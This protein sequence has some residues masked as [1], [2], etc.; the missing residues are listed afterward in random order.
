MQWR[1]LRERVPGWVLL[2]ILAFGGTL[3][4]SLFAV[5][6]RSPVEPA[7]LVIL[8][9]MA[10]RAAGMLPEWGR[11]GVKSFEKL[12]VVGIVLIGAGF[13]LRIV[14]RE[15][16]GILLLI[17]VTMMVGGGATWFCARRA[18]LSSRLGILLAVGTTICG[19]T[20]IA[21]CAPLLRAEE[22]ETS[23]A[24]GTV[25]IWGVL[26]LFTYPLLGS[27][28]GVED[29]LFGYF[30]GTAVHSTPQVVAAG[31]MYSDAAGEV[32][33]GVKLIRNCF[34]APLVLFLA[35]RTSSHAT[36]REAARG[37]PWFLFGYF[38]FAGCRTAELF[39]EPFFRESVALG[40]FFILCGMA[41]IGLNTDL[42]LVRRV[43][44]T[45]LFVGLFGTLTVAVTSGAFVFFFLSFSDKA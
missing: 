22:E 31:Y 1:E 20:A 16:V 6:G 42:A 3:L 13:D 32:A 38:L 7:L 41:G 24:I 19:G 4:S 45:P 15:G 28:L 44:M 2:G 10:M 27:L 30:V 18:A 35:F 39:P 14:Y 40:K 36:F 5:G 11:A 17:L 37:F 43:G 34:I 29:Q 8:G 23:Y 25:A 21:I 12:L 26:A 33:T 9:G